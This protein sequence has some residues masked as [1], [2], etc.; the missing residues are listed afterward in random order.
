MMVNH[1]RD[2]T[3]ADY[4]PR[5]HPGIFGLVLLSSIILLNACGMSGHTAEVDSVSFSPDGNYLL[6][7][8]H[9]GTIRLWSAK[10]GQ[11]IRRFVGHDGSVYRARFTPDG[12]RIVSSGADCIRLWDTNGGNEIGQIGFY[13]LELAIS[14]DGDKLAAVNF[15]TVNVWN[16]ATQQLIR[17]VEMKDY[18][19][20]FE[21][22]PDSD[23]LIFWDDSGSL[24]VL[25]LEGGEVRHFPLKSKRIERITPLAGS[26][27]VLLGDTEGYIHLWD[28]VRSIEERKFKLQENIH[29]I[30]PLRNG[31]T[32][33]STSFH[34]FCIWS[35]NDGT[36]LRRFS[37]DALF[38]GIPP[39]TKYIASVDGCNDSI[40]RLIDSTRSVRLWDLETG[41][42]LLKIS[43]KCPFRVGFG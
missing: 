27:L 13:G 17:S 14:P 10:T 40:A 9:D 7:A 22:L 20:S 3:K 34:E 6:T 26:S 8:S 23:A 41:R 2:S 24:N 38:T 21:F 18:I 43:Y 37:G 33:L 42:T 1:L 4:G 35:L 25:D 11:E 39:D 16:I 29:N 36:V 12:K 30:Y 15:E 32:V 5:S 19:S 28:R 31:Q